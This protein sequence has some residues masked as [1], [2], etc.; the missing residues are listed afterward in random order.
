MIYLLSGSSCVFGCWSEHRQGEDEE[1]LKVD[2]LLF[3]PDVL[4]QHCRVRRQDANISEYS[5]GEGKHSSGGGGVVTLLEPFQGAVVTHN[6]VPV[7]HE[8][9]LSPGDLVGLGQHYLFMFKDPTATAASQLPP[10]WVTWMSPAP[11]EEAPEG[12]GR[13]AWIVGTGGKNV[14]GGVGVGGR[15][16]FGRPILAW[17]DL[18]GRELCLPYE[19]PQEDRLLEEILAA[20]DPAAGG[21]EQPKLTPAFLLCLCIQHSAAHFKMANLRRLLLRLAS[22]IQLAMWVSWTHAI[23]YLY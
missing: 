11:G 8:A 12:R 10:N 5:D 9:A 14:S 23:G 3:A 19:L 17:R 21:A 15:R 1:R 7:K 18:E 6:G 4:P 13:A 16:R 2:V 20:V 22:Q